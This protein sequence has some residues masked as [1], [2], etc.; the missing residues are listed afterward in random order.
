MSP[1][2]IYLKAHSQNHPR[3]FVPDLG[4]ASQLKKLVWDL[5]ATVVGS[6]HIDL[7]TC[8]GRRTWPCHYQPEWHWQLLVAYYIALVCTSVQVRDASTTAYRFMLSYSSSD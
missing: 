5:N 3:P 4:D 7:S 6:M 1:P 2:P 8:G